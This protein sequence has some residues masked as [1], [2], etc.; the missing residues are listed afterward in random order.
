MVTPSTHEPLDANILAAPAEVHRKAEHV[1]DLVVV[2]VLYHAVVRGDDARVHAE[3]GEAL[4]QRA[5]DVGQAAGLGDGRA[6]GEAHEQYGRQPV[7]AF[8]EPEPAGIH[9]SL[10][11]I[12]FAVDCRRRD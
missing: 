11:T 4:G 10:Y 12:P 8:V 7:A 3:G 2:L 1:L 5:D 6:L 9:V